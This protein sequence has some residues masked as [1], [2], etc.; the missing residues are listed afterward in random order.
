MLPR[1]R[2]LSKQQPWDAALVPEMQRIQQEVL[3]PVWMRQWFLRQPMHVLAPR[4]MRHL[5]SW[6]GWQPGCMLVVETEDC[7]LEETSQAT[8][9]MAHG[10]TA[11]RTGRA[12]ATPELMRI[13]LPSVP[14]M[15]A[16][17]P[18]NASASTTQS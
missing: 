17:R 12:I 14:V 13:A 2:C 1:Q 9:M 11:E 7:V 16:V 10:E 3:Q 18:I 4:R 5:R 15:Q 6:T 8:T